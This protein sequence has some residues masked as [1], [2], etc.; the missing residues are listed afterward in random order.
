M[1][2]EILRLLVMFMECL[3]GG[4]LMVECSVLILSQK[5]QAELSG[6][7]SKSRCVCLEFF[8]LHCHGGVVNLRAIIESS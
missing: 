6:S 3:K 2:A 7:G 4:G 1:F 5:L 8:I